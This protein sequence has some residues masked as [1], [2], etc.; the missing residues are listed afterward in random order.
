MKIRLITFLG[1]F[2]VFSTMLKAQYKPVVIGLIFNPGLSWIKPDNNHYSSEGTSF[3]YSYGVDID[4][5]FSANY[6]FS[7]GLEIQHYT[8]VVSYPDLYS[9]TG[10]VADLENVSSTSTYSNVAFHIP[11]YLKLKSNPIGYN[12]FFGEFGLSFL[13]PFRANEAITSTLESGETV[14]RGSESNMDETNFTSVN[15]WL[16]VGMEFPLSGDTRFQIALRF[17]NGISSISKANAYRTDENGDVSNDEIINGGFPNGKNQA[18]YL[19]NL[20]LNLILVF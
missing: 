5:Y 16:A 9:S 17:I 2:L 15:L 6:A 13:F 3:S 19:K 20:S 7:T 1:V 11:T 8:G 12:S 14:D 10:N 4:F 18:Y